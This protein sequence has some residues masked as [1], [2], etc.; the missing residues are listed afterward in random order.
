MAESIASVDTKRIS[1]NPENP[2]LIFHQDELEALQDSIAKQG[3]LVPLT[4]YEDGKRGYIILDGERRWR[5]AIKLALPT[6]PVIVQPKPAPLQNLMMMFAIHHRRNEWDPLP[7]ALKL[8]RLEEL[9]VERYDQRPTE[10]QLAEIASLTR[11]EVRRYKKLLSLPMSYR[12]LLMKELQKP[13]SQQVLTVDH[14][15][16]ATAAASAVRKRGILDEGEE[17]QLRSAIVGRFQEKKIESTVAPRKFAR[18]ARAVEREEISVQRA[19]QVV[20]KFIVND[21]YSIGALFEETVEADDIRHSTELLVA[22]V[23]ERIRDLRERRIH[24]SDSLRAALVALADQVSKALR[25]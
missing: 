7:T 11:G 9:Y 15:L 3:I 5:C 23:D 18:L 22:R 20:K 17:D 24:L 16:E 1:P 2:R 19:R 6:V 14:V 4:V 12:S 25:D 13:R 8:E 10:K 21:N